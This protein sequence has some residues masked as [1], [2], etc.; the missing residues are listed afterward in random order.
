MGIGQPLGRPTSSGDGNRWGC[1]EVIALWAFSR[2][3]VLFFAGHYGS[4]VPFYRIVWEALSHGRLP[5]RD[6]PLDHPP[7]VLALLAIPG[8]LGGDSGYAVAFRGLLLAVDFA[9]LLLVGRLAASRGEGSTRRT[10]ELLYVWI[11]ALAF[12]LLL[13]RIDLVVCLL[14]LILIGLGLLAR[15]GWGYVVLVVGLGLN[16][17]TAWWWPFWLL[18]DRRFSGSWAPAAR[19]CAIAIAVAGVGL[20]A[21]HLAFG[22]GVAEFLRYNWSGNVE[23]ESLPATLLLMAAAVTRVPLQVDVSTGVLRLAGRGAAM[24]GLW[25]IGAAL[26]LMLMVWIRAAAGFHRAPARDDRADRL[27]W[28]S[29]GALVH[30]LAFQLSCSVLLPQYLLSSG[31]LACIAAPAPRS[32]SW[33]VLWIAIMVYTVAGVPLNPR[34]LFGLEPLAVLVMISRN[35]LLGFALG[36]ALE[37]WLP[38]GQAEPPAIA[39]PEAV[40]G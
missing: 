10:A 28:F 2:I 26:A 17:G 40:A 32:R 38:G 13:D 39:A 29:A 37:A 11:G 1:G 31:T 5:Y 4:D 16:V 22:P 21:A 9:V 6:I 18:S 25:T 35:V 20:W 30:L 3:L 15:F 27:R 7:L 12:P 14:I 23:V 34:A 19:R 24:A 8:V 36:W 33:V